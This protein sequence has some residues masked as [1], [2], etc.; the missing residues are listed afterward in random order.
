MLD[1]KE[2]RIKAEAYRRWEQEGRPHGQHDRHWQEATQALET[3]EASDIIESEGTTQA[4]KVPKAKAAKP[5]APAAK[6]KAAK[7]V[8][9][10]AKPALEVPKRA[11]AKKAAAE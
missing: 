2:E 4:L 11:R 6:P 7:A 1:K 10:A 9:E 3:G 5:K 8:A